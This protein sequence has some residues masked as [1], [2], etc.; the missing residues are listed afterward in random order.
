MRSTG[1]VSDVLGDARVLL[2]KQ[3]QVT[4]NGDTNHSCHSSHPGWPPVGKR[5]PKRTSTLSR[6]RTTLCSVRRRT[7]LCRI[8]DLIVTFP[9]GNVV[10]NPSGKCPLVFVRSLAMD[11]AC[12]ASTK[13]ARITPIGDIIIRTSRGTGHV[14]TYDSYSIDDVGRYVH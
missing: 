3:L 1:L 13:Q 10:P 6:R 14:G 12:A 7:T 11:G 2:A 8:P 5:P 9:M 4:G